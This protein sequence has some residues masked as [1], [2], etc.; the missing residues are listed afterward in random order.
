[1]RA[2]LFSW[3]LGIGGA[4]APAVTQAE[5]IGNFG[6]WYAFTQGE[7]AEKLCYMISAP[8]QSLGQ[9]PNRGEVGLMVTHQV[10]GKVRD[11]VSVAL[12]FEPHKTRYTKAKVDKTGNIL[13]RLVDGDR[14][15]IRDSNTDRTIVARMKK[16]A[17]LVVTGMTSN[18]V[19]SQ[20]TFSLDGF[21]RAY[22]AI[23]LACGLK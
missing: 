13:L 20:D 10:G 19:A 9:I 3:I 23:S 1:M 16:G 14:V 6:A 12:G 7:G 18:G 4:L 5:E 21:T 8:S 22:A 11:Q 15:W 17:E 2:R